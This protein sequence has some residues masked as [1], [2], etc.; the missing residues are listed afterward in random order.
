MITFVYNIMD[1]T[2]DSGD[3]GLHEII[4]YRDR[5]GRCPVMDY[6]DELAGQNGKDSRIKLNKVNDYIQA[7][8]VYGTEGLTENYVKRLSGGI[9]ELRPMKD[10][11]LFAAVVNGGYVLLHQFRKETRKT[12]A[13][14][15]DRAKRE[16]KDFLE[17]AD[18]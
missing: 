1:L 2:E 6:L 13:H 17:R 7:L 9:W 11:V 3:K 5:S 4:F 8:A 18:E 16:L 12:P 15:I 10:R 14:E